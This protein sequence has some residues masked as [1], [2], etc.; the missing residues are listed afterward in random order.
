MVEWA[1][2]ESDPRFLL[3]G[4]PWIGG[5]E[6]HYPRHRRESRTP[7]P[8]LIIIMNKITYEEDYKT[9]AAILNECLRILLKARGHNQGHDNMSRELVVSFSRGNYGGISSAIIEVNGSPTCGFACFIFRQSRT[10]VGADTYF[11]NMSSFRLNSPTVYIRIDKHSRLVKIRQDSP[12][13][14]AFSRLISRST[15]VL[16]EGKSAVIWAKSGDKAVHCGDWS[17]RP[18]GDT[19]DSK[20]DE[21]QKKEDFSEGG[22]ESGDTGDS[23][24]TAR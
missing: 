13:I 22:I 14:L 7:R 6:N 12:K 18:L 2:I 19:G 4:E 8:P 20:N 5:T 15:E 1:W 11:G 3:G 24:V 9:D 23:A 16:N 10:A 17:D 21:T